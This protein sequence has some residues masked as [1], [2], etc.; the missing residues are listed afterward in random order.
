MTAEPHP[1][2]LRFPAALI[3]PALAWAVLLCSSAPTTAL[4]Y[5]RLK[6]GEAVAGYSC[7]EGGIPLTWKRRCISYAVYPSASDDPPLQEILNAIDASFDSWTSVRCQGVPIE[8]EIERLK[9][10]S[11]CSVPQHNPDGPNLNSIAFVS[12]W[13]DR[14]NPPEA[15]ALTSVWHDKATGE[16]LDV[17][18]EM[19]EDPELEGILGKFGICPAPIE[20]RAG[21]LPLCAVDGLVDIQ[22]VVTHE[23]GHFLGLGHSEDLRSVMRFQAETRDLSKRTLEADDIEGICAIYPPGSLPEQCD[24][25]PRNGKSLQCYEPQAANGCGCRAAGSPGDD[26][27]WPWILAALLPAAILLRRRPALTA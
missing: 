12:D 3:A 26:S 14:G 13:L 1:G 9:D 5:C 7:S 22:N 11:R 23:A 10:L 25:A 16:I 8:I 21:E 24:F 19:N 6:A 27:S 15:F 2:I 20:T 17:D 4:A 18:M